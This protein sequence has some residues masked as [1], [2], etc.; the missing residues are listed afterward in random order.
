MFFNPFKTTGAP[1][2]MYAITYQITR[3]NPVKGAILKKLSTTKPADNIKKLN[4][5]GRYNFKFVIGGI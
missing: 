4:M 1:T 5:A 3:T 2:G